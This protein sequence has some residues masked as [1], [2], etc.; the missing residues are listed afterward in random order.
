MAVRLEILLRRAAGATL[1]ALDAG[2]AAETLA[3]GPRLP[4]G[5]QCLHGIR[6]IDDLTRVTGHAQVMNTNSFE[7]LLDLRLEGD[8]PHPLVDALAGC[9]SRLAPVIDAARS[10]LLV[11]HDHPIEEGGGPLIYVVALRK[12]PELSD[13]RF[14][15]YWL[16]THARVVR[17]QPFGRGYRQLHADEQRTRAAARALGVGIDDFGGTALAFHQSLAQFGQIMTSVQVAEGALSDESRFLDQARC[18][19]GL[20]RIT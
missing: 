7:A 15:D 6:A 13:A 3:I 9:A 10:A 17:P 20:Y 4:A 11:G 18:V 19:V 14:H 8:D 5:T 16:T 12:L 1:D 2:V